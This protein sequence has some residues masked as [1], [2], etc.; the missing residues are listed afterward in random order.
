LACLRGLEPAELLELTSTFSAP[1]FGNSTLPDD[2]AVALRAGHFDR[3]PIMIGSTRDE[4]RTF[5]ALSWPQPITAQEYGQLLRDAFGD[6]ADEVAARYPLSVYPSPTIAW[7]TVITDRV[8]ACTTLTTARL[9]AKRVPT[10]GYE[11]A[12]NDAP[13]IFTFPP[14][15]PPGAYHASE[16]PYLFG[17][18]VQLTAAQQRLA[19]QMSKYWTRFAYTGNP[20]GAGLRRWSPL[21]QHHPVAYVQSFAPD[22]IGPVNLAAEHQ[23]EFWSTLR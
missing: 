8:W 13:P 6:T 15:L 7:A 9:L 4:G 21:R 3:M 11:F 23:C 17:L 10:Y 12:D 22:A 20:N 5:L 14:H 19:N 1:A 18:N 16:L 2:P